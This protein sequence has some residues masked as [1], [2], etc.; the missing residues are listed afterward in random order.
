M[1]A[2]LATEDYFDAYSF[3]K[4]IKNIG[5]A[6]QRQAVELVN[7]C[8]LFVE[9]SPQTER[10]DATFKLAMAAADDALQFATDAGKNLSSE[11]TNAFKAAE[12]GLLK[13]EA[14]V[15]R[16]S[17]L[18]NISRVMASAK[19]QDKRSLSLFHKLIA[20]RGSDNNAPRVPTLKVNFVL[21]RSLPDPKPLVV[22]QMLS[23]R[24]R[25]SEIIWNFA[26]YTD[27]RRITLQ[28]NPHFYLKLP[29]TPAG[30]GPGFSQYPLKDFVLAPEDTVYV[31]A[32]KPGRVF[33]EA[34]GRNRA[35]GN[36]WRPYDA[37]IFKDICGMLEGEGYVERDMKGTA[38]MWQRRE[39]KTVS[40]P[41]STA[42]TGSSGPSS[43]PSP[44]WVRIEGRDWRTL[45][46]GTL[47]SKDVSVRICVGST[48]KPASTA[49]PPAPG[50]SVRPRHDTPGVPHDSA[51]TP[52]GSSEKAGS[53]TTPDHSQPPISG[54]T[55][56]SA[57]DPI[58]QTSTLPPATLPITG[59]PPAPPPVQPQS[60]LPLK[61][62]HRFRKWKSSITQKQAKVTA[63]PPPGPTPAH[64]P[65]SAVP[66]VRVMTGGPPR[67]PVNSVDITG[68]I[69]VSPTSQTDI[70]TKKPWVKRMFKRHGHR[71]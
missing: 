15:H 5:R 42:Y 46:Q 12:V 24:P 68:W 16:R 51:P 65:G 2:Q 14:K 44:P 47:D 6:Y 25:P 41:L 39:A 60:G 7:I 3:V 40:V 70:Y 30:Y 45:I 37:L 48:E 8:R 57:P 13:Y 4:Y 33:L 49:H 19:D 11:A 26:R 34:R 67:A 66:P 9:A 35:F 53:G 69:I 55:G 36:V 27:H 52:L 56:G 22:R 63:E 62:A 50:S 54:P 61:S 23:S 1:V 43:A 18:A 17:D 31:L 38:T 32:D 21:F 71:P 20:R 64:T 58:S 59:R 29:T 28:Q 10:H